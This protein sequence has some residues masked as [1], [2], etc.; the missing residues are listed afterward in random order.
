P[1]PLDVDYRDPRPAVRA[2]ERLDRHLEPALDRLDAT[3]VL[4]PRVL[5]LASEDGRDGL[6]R[7]RRVA[8]P[9]RRGP[10][11]GVGEVDAHGRAAHRIDAVFLGEARP[12]VV[13]GD[14]DAVAVDRRDL[15]VQRAED[16]AAE[17][18]ALQHGAERGVERG[19]V[20]D[21][22]DVAREVSVPV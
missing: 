11:A 15:A 22:A 10:G 18:R 8:V 3:R 6:E 21:R 1:P 5:L 2:P 17:R 20:D 4:E 14:D 19:D 12:R 7:P 9:G 16:G 13:D